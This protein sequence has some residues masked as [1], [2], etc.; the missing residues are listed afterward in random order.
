MVWIPPNSQA[1]IF[2]DSSKHTIQDAFYID[3]C[4][5]TN[6]E[7][8]EFIEQGYENPL[9]WPEF[10]ENGQAIS[11]EDGIQRFRNP[12]TQRPAPSTW[13]D[14]QIP[15]GKE[16]HPV[17]G[18]SWYEAAAYANF[19][20]KIL[21]TIYHW[22]AATDI[23][24]AAAIVP[25]SNFASNN[26][27]PVGQLHGIGPYGTEDMAGNVCEWCT[28]KTPDGFHYAVGGM[29]SDQGFTYADLSIRSPFSRAIGAGIR[30]IKLT[31][32]MPPD[33]TV[34]RS[35]ERPNYAQVGTDPNYGSQ[36]LFEEFYQPFYDYN[37]SDLQF[38]REEESQM[39][40][41]PCIRI[42][43]KPAYETDM[44]GVIYL[45]L[46]DEKKFAKPFQTMIFFPGVTGL[47]QDTLE[48]VEPFDFQH[49]GR[50][51]IY[52]VYWGIAERRSPQFTDS[53]PRKDPEYDEAIRRIVLDY[54][55][56]LDIAEQLPDLID[57]SKIAYYGYSWG[58]GL[59]PLLL[60][61]DNRCQVAVLHC[62]GVPPKRANAIT[63][64]SN[65]FPYVRT[66][67]LMVNCRYDA[68]FP[69]PAQDAMFNN[70]RLLDANQKKHLVYDTD[71]GHCAPREGHVD[72]AQKW[73]DQH[74]GVPERIPPR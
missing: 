58:A 40:G 71:Y 25:Q 5:V 21:P 39:F 63:E 53:Y 6:A 47:Y 38:Q 57:S 34:E 9:Y 42:T 52:P 13:S 11:F 14:G 31:A 24:F 67:T 8:Q 46:P 33:F 62:G 54:R 2:S 28:T 3:R 16:Q 27:V 60:A 4:E 17:H 73:M 41:H 30:C 59:G 1:E 65:F 44:E 12:V 23:Y 29:W 70:F 51:L 18:I 10:F 32:E 64:T 68:V 37:R 35:L 69:Q 7:F 15:P 74:M 50:I 20:G 19:R 56:S 61:M 49:K 26:T 48:T 72:E 66:P 55:R 43:Y 36:Q 22:Y 45:F